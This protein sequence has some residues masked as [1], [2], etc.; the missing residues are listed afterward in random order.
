MQV[1]TFV[2]DINIVL[3]P[4]SP[5]EAALCKKLLQGLVINLTINVNITVI[6][7]NVIIFVPGEHSISLIKAKQSTA[8]SP[9]ET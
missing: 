6:I 5:S 9:A 8:M 2:L 7:T 1:Q 3:G 4:L